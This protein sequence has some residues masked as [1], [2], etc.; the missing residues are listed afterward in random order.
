VPRSQLKAFE[1]QDDP[2]NADRG[3]IE[4]TVTMRDG[5]RRWCFFM[6]PE[7]LGNAGNWIPGT[8]VRFHYGA[9]HMIVVSDIDADIIEK[10][11]SYLDTEGELESCT[12]AFT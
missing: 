11:L 2:S 1:I 12:M 9:A 7:G 3:A 10:V 4:V 8:R 6:T 5:R